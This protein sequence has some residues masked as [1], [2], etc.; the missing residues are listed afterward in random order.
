MIA[1]EGLGVGALGP[2]AAGTTLFTGLSTLTR[3]RCRRRTS[4]LCTVLTERVHYLPASTIEATATCL[5]STSASSAGIYSFTCEE[6]NKVAEITVPAR[7]IAIPEDKA[8]LI[9]PSSTISNTEEPWTAIVTS[10]AVSPTLFDFS[11]EITRD[12]WIT[13]PPWI[14]PDN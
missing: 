5:A 4:P 14:L 1:L 8:V 12:D 7:T 11:V 6:R 10:R 2:A 9:V 3:E 13:F